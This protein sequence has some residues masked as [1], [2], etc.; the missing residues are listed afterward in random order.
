MPKINHTISRRDNVVAPKGVPEMTVFRNPKTRFRSYG[1][2]CLHHGSQQQQ[3][4]GHVAP[5]ACCCVDRVHSFGSMDI[6]PREAPGFQCVPCPASRGRF[7]APLLHEYVV[8]GTDFSAEHGVTTSGCHCVGCNGDYTKANPAVWGLGSTKYNNNPAQV[9]N[10]CHSLARSLARSLA[11][12]SLTHSHPLTL[13]H[14]H[15]HAP[16]LTRLLAHTC[17]HTLGRVAPLH[18]TTTR[19]TMGSDIQLP[20]SCLE[21]AKRVASSLFTTQFPGLA[22]CMIRGCRACHTGLTKAD[23]PA[24]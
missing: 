1:K 14:S 9:P 20:S 16:S 8:A 13:S 6:A 7:R 19:L 2:M 23:S 5:D 10:A 15:T 18:A 3:Q 17:Q 12:H 24:G 4:P 22:T 21:L 11:P